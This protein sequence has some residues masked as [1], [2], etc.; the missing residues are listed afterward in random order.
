MMIHEFLSLKRMPTGRHRFALGLMA[1]LAADQKVEPL[2][3]AIARALKQAEATQE[4]ELAWV[5][6]QNT[7]STAR[8]DSAKLDAEIDRQVSAIYQMVQAHTV[9]DKGD[10]VVD[11]AERY[12]QEFF[13]GGLRPITHQS[14]EVELS[15]L[16]SMLQRH[17][18]EFSNEA[19]LLG[20]SKGIER[21]ER[22]LEA[23]EKELNRQ[24]TTAMTFDKVRAEREALHEATCSVL[25]TA[26][27]HA[28]TLAQT[29]PAE[30]SRALDTLVA[31][32]RDQQ[33]RVTEARARHRPVSDIDP[34]SG[35]ELAGE[36][37]DPM[38]VEDWEPAPQPA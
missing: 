31:P 21:L 22:Q 9:G 16:Q 5:K 10:P 2:S 37:P 18:A 29:S 6:A 13:P 20:I 11:A 26:L 35:E 19:E 38:V 32:L 25:V 8:G 34:Q 27:H 17:H 28:L 36:V 3:E 12:L 14:Y 24:D 15:M 4:V 1:E 23:F 7:Q 30:A 33:R